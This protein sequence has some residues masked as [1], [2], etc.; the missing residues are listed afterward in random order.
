MVLVKILFAFVC[1]VCL[2]VPALARADSKSLV[3]LRAATKLAP[4][5]LTLRLK[6]VKPAEA[7]PE[8]LVTLG[9]L[10]WADFEK[11]SVSCQSFRTRTDQ[12]KP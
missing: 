5:D 4:E 6:L 9:R 12:T 10:L 7:T 8:A 11:M 3:R 2:V 1:S